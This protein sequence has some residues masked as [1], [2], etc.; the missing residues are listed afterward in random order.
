MDGIHDLGGRDGF[1]PVV[2]ERDEPVFHAP[3]ER[4]ARALVIAVVAHVPNPSGGTMRHSIER[5]DPALYLT[6]SYYEHWLMGAATMAVEAG[7][8]T[9]AELEERAGGAFPFSRPVHPEAI[10][11]AAAVAAE[12]AEAGGAR[13]A[14]GSRVRVRRWHPRG[15][16]RCPGYV[17]GRMGVITR[18]DGWYSVPDVEAHSTERIKEATYSVRFEADELWADGQAGVAVHVDL[19]DSYLD[20]A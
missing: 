18:A 17:M 8:V 19:W 20:A 5:L 13:F 11:E 3:W 12:A 14:V 1:G 15:H 16:T 9:A 2:V 4:T 7:I 6:T 10:A